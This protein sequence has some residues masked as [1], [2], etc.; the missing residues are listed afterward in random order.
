MPTPT[1][2]PATYNKT[3]TARL[4]RTRLARHLQ[5]FA[6]DEKIWWHVQDKVPEAWATLAEDIDSPEPRSKITLRLDDS[7]AKF[8]RALGPGYQAHMNRVLATYAQMQIGQIERQRQTMREVAEEYGTVLSDEARET[9]IEL[10]PQVADMH[11]EQ[12]EA[13]DMLFGVR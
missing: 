3:R 2:P 7:V 11:P 1:E 6:E 5:G 13:M 10:R 9:Y 12:L 4:A 8:Y